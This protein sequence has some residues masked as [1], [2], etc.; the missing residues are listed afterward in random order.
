MWLLCEETTWCLP[1]HQPGGLP[2]PDNPQVD[3]FAA[4]TAA[5][6]AWTAALTGEHEARVRREV[7]RRVLDPYR[8][9][10]DWRWL[11]LNDP[12]HLNNW[13]PWIHSNLLIASLL[14]DD[15]PQPDREPRRRRPRPLPRR[16]SR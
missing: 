1:A 15:Q 5:L 8:V 4:E 12:E 10:D 9:R 16:G 11:G 3:L 7:Q 6:L 13:T 14:L 2:D